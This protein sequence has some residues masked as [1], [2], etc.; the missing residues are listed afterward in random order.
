MPP[1]IYDDDEKESYHYDDDNNENYHYDDD[2]NESYHYDDDDNNMR[3]YLPRAFANQ[4][5]SQQG[6]MLQ[7][8]SPSNLTIISDQIV[9]YLINL[10]IISDQFYDYLIKLTI[11]SDEV[12]NL[13]FAKLVFLSRWSLIDIHLF[14][15]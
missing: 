14:F 11:I 9:D 6:Q 3:D 7:L 10:R 13:G 4:R 5:R 2:D 1:L 12:G 8:W 15:F